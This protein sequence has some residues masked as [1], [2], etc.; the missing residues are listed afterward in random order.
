MNKILTIAIRG[1]LC[2]CLS[3]TQKNYSKKNINEIIVTK[4]NTWS[5]SDKSYISTVM[6]MYNVNVFYLL[7]SVMLSGSMLTQ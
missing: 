2:I 6:F 4:N 3:N 5:E 1:N 7:T